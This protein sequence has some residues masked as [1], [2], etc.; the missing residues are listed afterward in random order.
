VKL[1]ANGMIRRGTI[2]EFLLEKPRVVSQAMQVRRRPTPPTH[3]A[4]TCAP[5]LY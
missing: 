3:T 1:D 2:K 4:A 5:R